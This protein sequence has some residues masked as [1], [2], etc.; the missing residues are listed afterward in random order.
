MNRASPGCRIA[1]TG[2][3]AANLYVCVFVRACACVCVCVC[4]CAYVCVRVCMQVCATINS[5]GMCK[6]VC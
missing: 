2:T 6:S 1:S 4:V 5:V 3:A